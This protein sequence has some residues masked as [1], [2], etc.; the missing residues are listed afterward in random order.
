MDRNIPQSEIRRKRIF[1]IIK[2][3]V[4]AVVV[5]GG[6]ATT[7]D[8]LQSRVKRSS[9]NICIVDS[10]VIEAS[11]SA[12]GKVVPAFEEV[13]NSPIDTR[14]VEVYCRSGDSVDVGTP[15]LKL[16]LQSI[17]NDY[18]N[19]QDEEKMKCYQMEQQ[20]INTKTSLSD[21]A[22]QIKIAEMKLNL[23]LVDYHNEQH[24]DSLGS[25]TADQVRRA[26]LAYTTARLELEQLKQR[27]ATE[28]KVKAADMKVKQLELEIF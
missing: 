17:E 16:D 9:L 21:M 1:N 26:E 13:I 19:L 6:I 5:I 15:L 24:L 3:A 22:M 8:W 25:G 28:Q 14:I 2:I 27:Y 11:I 20:E 10:G 7:I 18:R 23:L 12:Y 4:A